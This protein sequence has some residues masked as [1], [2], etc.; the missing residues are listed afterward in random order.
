MDNHVKINLNTN[1]KQAID[2]PNENIFGVGI[3]INLQNINI[4]TGMIL[5]I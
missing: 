4:R 5:L 3:F 2:K 1:H